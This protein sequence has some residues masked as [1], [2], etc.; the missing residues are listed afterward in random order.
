ML[1]CP[2]LQQKIISL[3]YHLFLLTELQHYLKTRAQVL[4]SLNFNKGS[5]FQTMPTGGHFFYEHAT[6]LFKFTVTDVVGFLRGVLFVIVHFC[7]L[8]FQLGPM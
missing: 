7:Q 8:V 5:A 2:L 6:L 1:H 4:F 3:L